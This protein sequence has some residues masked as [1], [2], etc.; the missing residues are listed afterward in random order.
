MSITFHELKEH[1]KRIDE[2]SLLEILDISSE[3]LV[4]RFSDIIEDRYEELREDFEQEEETES[5]G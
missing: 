3:E 4:E 1:L 2:T 5:D